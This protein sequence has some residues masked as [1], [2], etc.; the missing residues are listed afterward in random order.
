ML[1]EA[2]L[3]ALG[4]LWVQVA[5]GERFGPYRNA[6]WN[7]ILTFARIGSQHGRPREVWVG[8]RWPERRVRRYASGTRTIPRDVTDPQRRT[9][10]LRYTGR[11]T[12]H[13]KPRE[14]RGRKAA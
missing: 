6:R 8:R 4:D 14:A 10:R 3:A 12:F 9:E 2:A 13:R 5:D 1:A 7:E 11:P